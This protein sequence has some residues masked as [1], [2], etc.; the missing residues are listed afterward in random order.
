MPHRATWGSTG[1]VREAVMEGE[2]GQESSCGF[3]RK[4]LVRQDKRV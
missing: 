1:L 4:E 2:H 3:H